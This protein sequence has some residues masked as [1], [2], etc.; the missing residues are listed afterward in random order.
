MQNISIENIYW[1][2]AY[3][4]RCINEKSIS[5]MSSEKFE[6]IYDVVDEY[7]LVNKTWNLHNMWYN[8]S[9]KNII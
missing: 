1:M 8:M 3:A 4:F 7:V 6:N 2:L 9:I 5:K